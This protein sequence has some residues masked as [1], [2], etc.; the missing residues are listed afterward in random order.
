VNLGNNRWGFKPELGVSYPAGRWTFDAYAGVWLFTIN[1]QYFPGTLTKRQ[2]PVIA[3]QSHVSYALPRRV[4]L[5]FDGT[6]FSGGETFVDGILNP[7][8]QR[9]SRLGVT[10]SVPAGGQHSLKF[11]YSTGAITRRGSDFDTVAVTWQLVKL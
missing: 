7:D 6:W 3:L 5:A 9:N 1:N 10:L 8:R 4:W 11:V 2:E